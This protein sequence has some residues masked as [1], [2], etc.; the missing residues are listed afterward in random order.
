MR[1]TAGRE[2]VCCLINGRRCCHGLDTFNPPGGEVKP[3]RLR[4]E[5]G[6][7]VFPPKLRVQDVTRLV[8]T[9]LPVEPFFFDT[10]RTGSEADLVEPQT[11]KAQI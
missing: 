8:K 10:L 4:R 3:A 11:S 5:E 7:I 2:V 9:E 6:W 1:E